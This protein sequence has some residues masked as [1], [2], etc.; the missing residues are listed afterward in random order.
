EKTR[1]SSQYY[2]A[3]VKGIILDGADYYAEGIYETGTSYAQKT[4][5]CSISAYAAV[6]GVNY[7][8]DC[9]YKPSFLLQY[10]FGSGDRD[11]VNSSAS[12]ANTKSGDN[13]FI[14]FGTFNG[15]FALRPAL[16]NIHV[17]RAGASFLPFSES[18]GI[19]RRMSLGLRYLYYMK[20]KKESVIAGAEPNPNGTDSRNL[21]QGADIVYR[22]SLFHDLSFF[23]NYG[24]FIPGSAYPA[25]EKMRHILTAG[26]NIVF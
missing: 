16:S 12:Y 15:G 14:S 5:K 26:M 10:G 3:G 25:D 8:P 24:L 19:A 22:W 23:A 21:G 6:G 4:E 2:S 18:E 1:Y 20:D 17:L 9:T 7:Y 11:R 13:G